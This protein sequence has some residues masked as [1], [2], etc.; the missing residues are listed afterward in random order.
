[1]VYSSLVDTMS[2]AYVSIRGT[3]DG[4]I[5]HLGAG[6][7]NTLLAALADRLEKTPSFFRG[8]RVALQVGPRQ[9]NSLQLE[10]VGNLLKRYQVSLWAVL[11]DSAETQRVA[12]AMGL[13]TLAAPS[14]LGRS[15]GEKTGNNDTQ[16]SL[17]EQA[18]L[19]RRILRSGQSIH[20]SGH[21]ALI[22]DVNPGAEIVASGDVLVWGRLRGNVHA[23][24]G[25]NDGAV[26]CALVLSPMLL[27]IGNHIARSPGREEIESEDQPV[28]PEMA[29]VHN[30]QIL[31]ESW[32]ATESM[33][34][35]W[36]ADLLRRAANTL[37]TWF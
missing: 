17:D 34:G 15:V 8:G 36:R 3:S 18:I 4:L 32:R 6:D 22:G 19:V 12:A 25:G 11:G 28:S 1:M 7:W 9:L 21:V 5:V 31:A 30:G 20:H 35:D 24:A 14:H 26:V 2:Q 16:P 13:E 10:T 29:F 33:Y 37:S 27:R 23:G